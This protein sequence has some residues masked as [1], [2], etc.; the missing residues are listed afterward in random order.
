MI[1]AHHHLWDPGDRPYPWMEASVAAIARPFRDADLRDALAGAVTAGTTVSGT[2]VVQ[3]A[4]DIGETRWLLDRE[5][6]VLGVVGWVDLQPPDV[7]DV[8]DELHATPGRVPLVGL[9]HMAQNEPDP[10]WLAR[11]DV[12]RG[13]GL[14]TRAGLT[15][16]LLVR[17]REA[18]AALALVDATPDGT[19]VL[20]HAAKPRI[21]VSGPGEPGF[22]DWAALLT[23]FAARPNVVCKLSGLFTE[24][25]PDWARRPVRAHVDRILEVFG[26]ARTLFGSDWPVSSL[27][28]PYGA[29][30]ERTVAMLDA[31]SP[32]ERADVLGGTARRAYRL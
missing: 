24:A 19:F 3:A 13:V 14:A 23:A 8:L 26:P 1:D 22:A 12:V 10:A 16:D 30:V 7:A 25:G 15:M 17:S 21:D 5:P 20:D 11:P 4:H 2:V 29:V 31:L 6:P 18:R 28:M 9:R 32:T 27:R